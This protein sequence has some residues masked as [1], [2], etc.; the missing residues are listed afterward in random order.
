MAIID[1]RRR[2]PEVKAAS[3]L[4]SWI[5]A[6]R[7]VGRDFTAR[8]KAESDRVHRPVLD[9]GEHALDGG[10][11]R[12]R[13]PSQQWIL[14]LLDDDSVH[15]GLDRGDHDRREK[16]HGQQCA[17]FTRRVWP[18]ERAASI[19]EIIRRKLRSEEIYSIPDRQSN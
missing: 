6:R 12:D 7:A 17:F 8:K 2:I 19:I 13:K 10:G 15:P 11:C 18:R 14:H 3:V 5:A 16:R 1:P 4:R 9:R